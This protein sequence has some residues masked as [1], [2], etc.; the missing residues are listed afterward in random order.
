MVSAIMI[1]DYDPVWPERFQ[2]LRQKLWS[3]MFDFALSIEHVG[4]TSVPGLA[5]KPIVDLDIV[6]RSVGDISTA[7][8]RLATLGYIHKGDVGVEGREAFENPP[9]EEDHH[10][11]V[12]PD[13]SLGLRNHL[14][15][16][17]YLRGNPEAARGYGELKKTLAARYP[18][19]IDRYIAGKTEFILRI[20]HD[21]GIGTDEL[22]GIASAN[23][24]PS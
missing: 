24:L 18:H 4:S 10:L 11:Y 20:L 15:L 13:G 21:C 19:D 1:R 17:D 5:A 3:V 22:E 12:C 14:A 6:V 16:R 7:I 8:T 9:G 23:Q 2:A